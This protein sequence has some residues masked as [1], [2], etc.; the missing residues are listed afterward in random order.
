MTT[1]CFKNGAFIK[2][3]L[4]PADY[5]ALYMKRG[6]PL[7]EIA[8]AGRSNVGKSTLLNHLFLSKNLVK[9]SS[10]PGKTQAINFFTLNDQLTFVDLP[11]YGYAHVSNQ[12][13]KDWGTMIENYLNQRE[14][15]KLILFLLDIR[16]LP[17]EEDLQMMRWI[18]AKKLPSILVLTKVDKVTPSE[19]IQKTKGILQI[20]D[21]YSLPSL[22]PIHY[23]APKNEGRKQ[24]IQK[25]IS[26]LN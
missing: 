5:P 16:R 4:L 14:C 8:V 23:S 10:E 1:Y 7:P 15:L 13:K 12:V 2:T 26:C 19:K 17:A 24:L 25:I 6:V 20:F 21:D 18:A 22:T 11:G 9:T 3:A